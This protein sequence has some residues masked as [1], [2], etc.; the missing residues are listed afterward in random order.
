MNRRGDDMK[1]KIVVLRSY[2][3]GGEVIEKGR[4]VELDR[5]SAMRLIASNKAALAGEEPEPQPEPDPEPEP[6]EQKKAAAKK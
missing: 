3:D 2:R 1:V 6:A 5:S 4:T